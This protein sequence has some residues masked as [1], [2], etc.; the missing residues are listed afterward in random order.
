[1]VP[2]EVTTTKSLKILLRKIK[3]KIIASLNRIIY[4]NVCRSTNIKSI[5]Y[6]VLSVKCKIFYFN[7]L[8][9]RFFTGCA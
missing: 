5:I 3:I 1:M 2:I 8:K 7:S 6:F 4:L 9:D